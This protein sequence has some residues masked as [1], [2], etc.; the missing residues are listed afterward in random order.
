[1]V[2]LAGPIL[3]AA[4]L[5]APQAA[6]AAGGPEDMP[7]FFVEFDR[8]AGKF[9]GRIDSG[10][11]GCVR[12]RKITLHRKRNGEKAKIGA[13][14]TND[15]GRFKLR[16]GSAKKARYFAAARPS[17]YGSDGAKITCL[18]EKSARI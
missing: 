17:S 15:K 9:E 12:D 16:A 13:V 6:G 5:L 2:R 1:M 8:A 11:P 10:K 18:A 14:R 7:T 3:I 4:L